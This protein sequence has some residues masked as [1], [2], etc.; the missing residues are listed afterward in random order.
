MAEENWYKVEVSKNNENTYHYYGKSELS[1][2]QVIYHLQ[3]REYTKLEELLYL[4][5]N[6]YK[7]WSER[8]YS[9]MSSVSINPKYVI[10]IME[11]NST[12]LKNQ[13]LLIAPSMSCPLLAKCLSCSGSTS[14]TISNFFQSGSGVLQATLGTKL[15]SSINSILWI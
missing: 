7:E 1:H 9:V 13:S 8:D 11:Y 2:D 6:D 4:E 10:S 14:A 15:D 3:H 12:N 5:G